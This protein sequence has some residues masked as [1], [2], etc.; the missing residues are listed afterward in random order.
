MK[1]ETHHVTD[2]TMDPRFEIIKIAMI[3]LT[4]FIDA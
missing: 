2:T 1:L 3:A 4:S